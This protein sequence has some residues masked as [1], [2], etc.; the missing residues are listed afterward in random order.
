MV[1]ADLYVMRMFWKQLDQKIIKTKTCLQAG[2]QQASRAMGKEKN[3]WGLCND[4]LQWS[5]CG[6]FMSTE[7]RKKR[8]FVR[9][10]AITLLKNKK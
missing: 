2:S 4:L 9:H 1:S 8:A 10:S 6:A 7:Y 5:Q 3:Q